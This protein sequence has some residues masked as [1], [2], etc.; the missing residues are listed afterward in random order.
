MGDLEFLLNDNAPAVRLT[1]SKIVDGQLIYNLSDT[2]IKRL[3]QN[4]VIALRVSTR[5]ALENWGEKK[6]HSQTFDLPNLAFDQSNESR[7]KNYFIVVF[8]CLQQ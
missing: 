7:L 3:S 2:A 8:R 5:G 4:E 6:K 1:L